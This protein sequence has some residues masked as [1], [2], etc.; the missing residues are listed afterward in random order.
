M[1]PDPRPCDRLHTDQLGEVGRQLAWY[2]VK[3]IE[4]AERANGG[5][6]VMPDGL[7]PLIQLLA[8]NG[9]IASATAPARVSPGDVG[10]PEAAR[11]LGLSPGLIRR[12]AAEGRIRGAHKQGRDWLCPAD[13]IEDIRIR[14][15][16]D[17]AA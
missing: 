2:A 17:R 8:S 3:G 11:R 5:L 12:W 7:V 10:V 14:R 6:P 9:S 16:R 15:A 1:R 4:A 13:A